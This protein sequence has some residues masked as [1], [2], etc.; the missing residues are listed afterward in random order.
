MAENDH[1][2]LKEAV[3]DAYPSMRDWRRFSLGLIALLIE[4]VAFVGMLGCTLACAE[5]GYVRGPEWVAAHPGIA[6][7]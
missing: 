5:L 1:D 6:S 7:L 2:K 4:I 3:F